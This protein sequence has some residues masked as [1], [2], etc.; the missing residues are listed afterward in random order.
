MPIDAA[1]LLVNHPRRLHR[2]MVPSHRDRHD[3]PVKDGDKLQR[4]GSSGDRHLKFRTHESEK[5]VARRF[6]LDSRPGLESLEARMKGIR[7]RDF[8]RLDSENCVY[9]DYTGAM[10]APSTLVRDHT[11]VLQTAILGNPHSVNAPSAVSSEHD[12]DA[13]AAVLRMARA[14]SDDYTVVWTLNASGALKTVAEAYPFG[15]QGGILYAPDCH[16]SVVRI[17][18]LGYRV[19][20]RV[21]SPSLDP[22]EYRPLLMQIHHIIRGFLMVSRCRIAVMIAAA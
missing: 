10:L 9:L 22:M 4:G 19:S 5:E 18:A 7:S 11:S 17:L 14:S 20:L 15:P 1:N 16:N 3:H 6:F 21:P 8:H 12:H 2:A 13:R